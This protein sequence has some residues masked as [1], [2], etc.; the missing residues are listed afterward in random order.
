MAE[1]KVP[2]SA[3]PMAASVNWEGLAR[4][5]GCG[6]DEVRSVRLRPVSAENAERTPRSTTPQPDTQAGQ[7][8]SVPSSRFPAPG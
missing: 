3:A 6:V 1:G 8:E 2:M 5:L 7:I 4:A